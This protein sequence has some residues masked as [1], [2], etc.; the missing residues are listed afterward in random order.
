MTT[1]STSTVRLAEAARLATLLSERVLDTL[2]MKRGVTEEEGVALAKVARLLQDYDVEWPPLLTQVIH[3]LV[4][5]EAVAPEVEPSKALIN[6]VAGGFSRLFSKPRAQ[7][8]QQ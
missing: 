5:E 4:R 6:M 2:I 3:E 1:E 8:D 7:P